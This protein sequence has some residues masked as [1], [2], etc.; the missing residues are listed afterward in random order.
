MAPL[1]QN[2]TARF[3]VDY[4]DDVNEHTAMVRFDATVLDV[5]SALDTYHEFLTD[6]SDFLYEITI[7]GARWAEQGSDISIPVTW[8]GDSTY[9][10]DFMPPL[11]GP[12]QTRWEGRDSSGRKG[13]LSLYGCKY[14][15]PDSYRIISIGAN[16]PNLG[17]LAINAGSALGSFQSI[18]GNRMN[19]KNYVNVNFNSYWEAE[20]RP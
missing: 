15:T 5:P 14:T 17:V 20:A 12:R 19:M 1:P 4:N 18:G 2:N 10:T 13:S 11:L 16:L 9:G 8:P 3:W 7:I 6:I